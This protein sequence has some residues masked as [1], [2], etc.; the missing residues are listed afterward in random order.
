MEHENIQNCL[1]NRK[2]HAKT[3]WQPSSAGHSFALAKGPSTNKCPMDG[4]GGREEP[5]FTAKSVYKNFL[6]NNY[7]I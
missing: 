7:V 5:F 4:L 2:M 3:L 6:I 1:L